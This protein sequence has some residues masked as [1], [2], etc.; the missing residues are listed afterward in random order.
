MV[1]IKHLSL[2]IDMNFLL[3]RNTHTLVKS[4]T[5]YSDLELS[6]KMSLQSL[7][8]LYPFKGIYIVADSKGSWRKDIYSDYKGK[9]KENR[10]KLDIDWEFVFTI[11][12][13]FKHHLSEKSKRYVF[14]EGDNIE[15]DDWIAHLVNKCNK[16]EESCM[17]VSCDKDLTQLLDFSLAPSYINFQ[18]WDKFVDSVVYLPKNYSYFMSEL[19]KN[20]GTLFDMNQNE[21]VID[22]I[23]K[24]KRECSVK[25]INTE[26]LLITKLIS[27]DAGDN[28]PSIC[29]LPTIS[30]PDKYRGIGEKGAKNIYESYKQDFPNDIIFENDKWIDDITNYIAFYK[31][32]NPDDYRKT[33]KE[34]LIKN[35]SLIHLH[36]NHLPD[37]I[38]K[39]ILRNI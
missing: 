17:I 4:R 22:L 2:I 19:N 39:I 14:L 26:E 25:E 32:V 24:L 5:L 6:L 7:T 38:K 20:L 31:K 34:N 16:K 28:I 37:E 3:F 12:E 10:E 29:K 33:I 35:R 23:N 27:G 11:Y 36:E 1:N 8:E 15:G 9:R 18:Y 13:E 21:M 30:N